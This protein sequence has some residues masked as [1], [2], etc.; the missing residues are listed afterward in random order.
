MKRSALLG[1]RLGHDVARL[2]AFLHYF[3]RDVERERNGK[4]P[5]ALDLQKMFADMIEF[6]M[7]TPEEVYNMK[8][9]IIMEKVSTT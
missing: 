1:S 7:A 2:R 3:E 8:Q 6:K 9:F 5:P 4:L